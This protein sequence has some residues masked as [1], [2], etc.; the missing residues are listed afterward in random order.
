MTATDE[1]KELRAG[2]MVREAATWASAQTWGLSAE[3]L[4]QASGRHRRWLRRL[5]AQSSQLL[6]SPRRRYGLVGLALALGALAV[7]LPLALSSGKALT[8]LRLSSYSL[9]LPAVFHVTPYQRVMCGLTTPFLAPIYPG[10]L[11]MTGIARVVAADASAGRCVMMA[12]LEPSHAAAHVPVRVLDDDRPVRIGK[13]LGLVGSTSVRGEY[14]SDSQGR[15]GP[16]SAVPKYGTYSETIVA[17]T[18]AVPLGART[19]TL[20]IVEHGF[21]QKEFLGIVSAG[22]HSV[23]SLPV[24]HLTTTPSTK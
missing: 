13:Y 4:R 15:G 20:E 17:L 10:G 14:G 18:L 6:A 12:F 24:M 21:S 11:G 22:L 1:Q 19:Q 5:E 23:S 7:T 2:E 3:Q 8:E 9:R 16:F